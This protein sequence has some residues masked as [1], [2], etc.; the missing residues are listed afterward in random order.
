MDE[1]AKAM[2]TEG[3]YAII[4]GS[5]TAANMNEWQK[6]IKATNDAKYPDIKQMDLRPCD[7]LKDKAFQE[8]TTLLNKYP[9][10]KVIMAICSP[11]VPGA[12]AA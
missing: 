12:S 10:L 6:H 4:T 3:E 5:L 2:G 7:D 11:A 1:A 9:N 8:A